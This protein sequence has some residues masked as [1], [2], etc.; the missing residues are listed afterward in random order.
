M[1]KKLDEP[2]DDFLWLFFDRIL[3]CL[4]ALETCALC[5]CVYVFPI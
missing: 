3:F 5:V 4:F 1:R 2:N